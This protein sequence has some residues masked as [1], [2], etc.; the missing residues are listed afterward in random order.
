MEFKPTTALHKISELKKRIWVIE[1]G[2]GAGKTIAILMII[3]DFALRGKDLEIY[4][5]SQELT[6]MRMTVI[7][8]FKKIMRSF[9]LFD[10]RKFKGD[11]LYEFENGSFIKFIGLDKED[12]GK[13]LRSDLV[14]LNE[15]NK[16]NFETYRELTS[17]ADRIIVDFNPNL[18]F[19]A[20]LELVP[21]DDCDN[22]V[23]T[24]RDNEYCPENE[25]KEILMYKKL[26]YNS[27]GTVRSQYWENKWLIYGMG[28]VGGIEGRIFN[29]SEIPNEVFNNLEVP[30]YYYADWGKSHPFAVAEVKYYDGGLYINELNYKSENEWRN[31]LTTTEQ[32][33]INAVDEGF[34]SWL[35][36]KLNVN[37]KATIV[38]DNNR[39]A[40]I[41]ALRKG[42]WERAVGTKKYQGVIMD[43]IDIL[44]NLEVYYTKSSENIAYEQSAYKWEK[45]RFGTQ[46]DSAE[47][48]N[49]HH[50]DGAGYIVLWLQQ[51]GVI[52]RV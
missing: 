19:W 24:Y 43:R 26:A 11:T 15:A 21:R 33:Q 35:F 14:F 2:Q 22:L 45:D 25:V 30:I 49:N 52:N 34:V 3:I 37:K 17:R 5:A 40:K 18:Q 47:D 20:H 16:T 4:I 48:K 41:T 50:M 31:G 51:R 42:G 29:W 39:P 38:C 27:D 12:I 6:K 7:K 8:D 44:Q 46:I 36:T 23:L 28:L 13:G 9:G 1:G 32:I 10:P